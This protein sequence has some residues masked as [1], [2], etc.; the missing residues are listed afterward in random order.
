MDNF[1]VKI[2]EK[3][4]NANGTVLI[5]WHISPAGELGRRI[6]DGP[7]VWLHCRPGGYSDATNWMTVDATNCS[8]L[9]R[10][11]E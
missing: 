2:G 8:G 7:L 11:E 10:V 1:H 6:S 9:E 3:Y 4:R 5:V